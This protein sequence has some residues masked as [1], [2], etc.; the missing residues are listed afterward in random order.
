MDN[1][2]EKNQFLE[3]HTLPELS[4]GGIIGISLHPLKK[5]DL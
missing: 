5:L 1:L 3:N 4:Q 2:E